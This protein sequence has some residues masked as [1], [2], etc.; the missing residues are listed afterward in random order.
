LA[1]SRAHKSSLRSR[2]FP[3]LS[4]PKLSRR[5]FSQRKYSR[6]KPS[7]LRRR[8]RKRNLRRCNP[9]PRSRRNLPPRG[10]RQYRCRAAVVAFNCRS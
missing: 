1:E 10:L 4:P 9:L 5:K 2:S 8:L 3:K 6:R 7:P